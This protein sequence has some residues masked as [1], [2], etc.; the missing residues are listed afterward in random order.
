MFIYLWERIRKECVIDNTL[1]KKKLIQ[2]ASRK[3]DFK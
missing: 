1:D 2:Y 3:I